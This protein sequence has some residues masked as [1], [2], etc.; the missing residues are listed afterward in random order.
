MKP[1]ARNL[2]GLLSLVAVLALVLLDVEDGG[3]P[4]PLSPP[5][6]RLDKLTGARGCEECHGAGG[7]SL[8][9]ACSSCHEAIGDELATGRGLHGQLEDAAACGACHGEHHGDAL[10][11]VDARAFAAA[12]FASQESYDHDGLGFGL[13]GAHDDL[14]CSA[15]HEQADARFAE[16]PRFLGASQACASCHESPHPRNLASSCTDCHDQASPFASAASFEHASSFA[17]SGVHA[18]LDCAACHEAG[19]AS[20]WERAA[21]AS[22][23]GA[24]PS[25]R[26]CSACHD[27]PHGP[28]LLEAE[29]DCARC[30]ATALAAFAEPDPEPSRVLHEALGM[31][32]EGAH[33]SLACASCH[34]PAAPFEERYPGREA[35]S[36]VTCHTD[37]HGGQF[38]SADG[39]PTAC[40]DCHSTDAFAPSTFDRVR[41]G[42]L[43]FP[44]EGAHA[45]AACADC[46]LVPAEGAP[47]AFAGL[48][49]ACE[50]CHADPHGG[51]FAALAH[52][53]DA[54]G[55]SCAACHDST[56]TFTEVLAFDHAAT[57]HPLTGA[58]LTA[59]CESC[60]APGADRRLGPVAALFPG[61]PERCATCHEDP[62]ADAFEGRAADPSD[63]AACHG[64]ESFGA[65]QDFEHAL[66]GFALRGAHEAAACESCHGAGAAIGRRLGRVQ[67]H[68]PG[69]ASSCA[70]CHTDPHGGLF[71]RP[72]LARATVLGTGCARCHDETAFAGASEAFD[73][74]AWTGWALEGAHAETSCGGCHEPLET[75]DLLGRRSAPALGTAC[76]DCHED[77][78]LG[79]FAPSPGETTDCRRCHDTSA[80]RVVEF[81]HATMTRFPLDATHA[82]LACSDCHQPWPTRSGR[83]VVRYRPLGRTCG[84]CHDAGG[85]DR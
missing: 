52:G 2:L 32:L 13:S 46:H 49:S 11:L 37:P 69:D 43:A 5:H 75:P 23:A 1:T 81:D 25:T 34:E 26:A 27:S 42:L 54:A 80:F 77:P 36:C 74:G 59:G 22:L 47:V 57:G 38:R 21:V 51:L 40:A 62:H 17:L 65:V 72:E 79:Q 61:D 58:H 55:P 48:E 78:H 9:T 63:C 68:F 60:H 64:T 67:D 3:G 20:D 53:V 30:H 16:G 70:T 84:D 35:S 24:P 31:A 85:G 10:A 45:A 12:G 19:Q 50:G 41:H 4:G 28:G 15:C 44:L 73:H 8:A 29:S 39:T 56:S 14:A 82:D 6:A 83:E 7:E 76:A 33:A 18:G 66:T 71:D